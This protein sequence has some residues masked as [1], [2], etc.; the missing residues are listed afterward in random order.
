[1]IYIPDIGSANELIYTG[2]SGHSL[3]WLTL[4]KHL[5]TQTRLKSSLSRPQL[6][7]IKT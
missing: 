7:R 6:V 5:R 1:M 3:K 2:L 4:K